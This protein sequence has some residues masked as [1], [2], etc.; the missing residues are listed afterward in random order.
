M[1]KAKIGFEKAATSFSYLTCKNYGK[2]HTK[3]EELY[4]ET[5]SYFKLTENWFYREHDAIYTEKGNTVAKV[6]CLR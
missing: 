1:E 5:I 2:L 3:S 6:L 4:A